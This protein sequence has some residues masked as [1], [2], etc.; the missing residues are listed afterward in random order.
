MLASRPKTLAGA[1]VPVAIGLALAWADTPN[2]VHQFNWVAA[3]LCLL[4]AFVMQIDANFVND[5]FDYVK[6]TD[7]AERR[8]GPRRACAQGWVTPRAMRLAMAITTGIAC[9]IGLPL[10]L[11]GGIEMILVGATCVVFCFLYTTYL[12]YVG[13]GDVLVI[14]FFGLVPVCITYY[15]QLHSCTWQVFVASAACG[16][17]ID[18][19]LIINN[20]RDRDLDREKGKTTIVVRLGAQNGRRLYLSCGITGCIGGIVFVLFGHPLA[21]ALPLVTY[22]PLHASTYRKIVRIDRGKALNACLGETSRNMLVY[23]LAVCA[24][25]LIW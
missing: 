23:G 2:A 13:L 25:L 1:A 6:G 8:L 19:L 20:Y 21:F 5:Y 15:I 7:D 18:T 4:F 11:Y 14:I 10:V 16:F 24:G 17:V 9:A 22:L 12:S 3:I